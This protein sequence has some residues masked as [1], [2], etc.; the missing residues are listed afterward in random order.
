MKLVQTHRIEYVMMKCCGVWQCQN[1]IG[2]A[3]DDKDEVVYQGKKYVFN[4]ASTIVRKT[5]YVM[6]NDLAGVMTWDLATDVPWENPWCLT[7]VMVETMASPA[8]H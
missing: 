7:K 3:W 4:G 1:E 8:A 6:D 2:F 5:Q